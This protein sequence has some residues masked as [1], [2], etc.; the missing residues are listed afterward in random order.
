MGYHFQHDG[1]IDNHMRPGPELTYVTL[2]YKGEGQ[3]EVHKILLRTATHFHNFFLR[4]TILSSNFF[5]RS[6]FFF[7]SVNLILMIY[8]ER[9]S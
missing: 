9:S 1:S 7:G 4:L 2:L 5:N 3:L 6:R 8:F